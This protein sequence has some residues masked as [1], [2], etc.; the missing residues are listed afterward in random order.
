VLGLTALS[1]IACGD[2]ATERTGDT[3]GSSQSTVD[4]RPDQG[5]EEI[6]RG[7]VGEVEWLLQTGP[8]QVAGSA[9][10]ASS[11]GETDLD[12][13]GIDPCLKFSSGHSDC[14]GSGGGGGGGGTNFDWIYWTAAPAEAI[15]PF[16]VVSTTLDAASVRITTRTDQVTEPFHQV[17]GKQ[18]WGAVLFV[19]D[20][21]E[22]DGACDEGPP[23][24]APPED[25]YAD[26]RVDAL[27]AE[28]N[29]AGCLGLGPGSHV[30]GI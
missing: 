10:D 21:G 24:E 22:A 14:G 1:L 26:M 11:G 20:P 3:Q 13:M 5:R 9:I 25:A 8:L 15:P 30:G 29:V 6:A 12:E 2:P 19:D 16:V 23:G 17:A 4:L 28:G 27:D 18:L 7:M